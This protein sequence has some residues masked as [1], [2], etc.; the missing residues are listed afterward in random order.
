M[1]AVLYLLGSAIGRL[2]NMRSLSK[3]NHRLT[4]ANHGYFATCCMFCCC[5][6]I[7]IFLKFYSCVGQIKNMDAEL[8]KY[9]QSNRCADG[10]AGM[11]VR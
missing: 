2:S 8:E 7:H 1:A 5:E 4:V 11:W 6:C 10:R 9:H 3:W